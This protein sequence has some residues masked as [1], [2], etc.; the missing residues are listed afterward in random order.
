MNTVCSTKCGLAYLGMALMT[1]ACGASQKTSGALC[2]E[3]KASVDPRALEF[4]ADLGTNSEVKAFVTAARG[5]IEVAAQ[6]EAITTIA[7]MRIAVDLGASPDLVAQN[8]P[9]AVR[10][11]CTEAANRIKAAMPSARLVISMKAP[12]CTPN[13]RRL[14]RCEAGCALTE[15]AACAM[16][17]DAEARLYGSCSAARVEITNREAPETIALAQTLARNLPWLI[18]AYTALAQ[19]LESNVALIV[20][21][22]IELPKRWREAGPKEFACVAISAAEVTTASE[23]LHRSYQAGSVLMQL[24][25][26]RTVAPDAARPSEAM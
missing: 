23:R 26:V 13:E 6:A 4:S 20:K 3:L 22:G 21:T 5:V 24:L 25:G 18:H 12:S 11:A 8:T 10:T 16:L 7:C 17:C 9:D 2:P 14:G 19:Q 1:A 15:D